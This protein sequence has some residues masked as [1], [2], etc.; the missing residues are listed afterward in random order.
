MHIFKKKSLN[1]SQVRRKRTE[2]H[3]DLNITHTFQSVLRVIRQL[4]PT[5]PP[6]QKK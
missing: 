5:H 1:Q 6:P 3:H 2:N 4:P